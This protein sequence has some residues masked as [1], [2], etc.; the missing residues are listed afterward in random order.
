MHNFEALIRNA[1]QNLSEV[2][3]MPYRDEFF[4]AIDLLQDHESL[5]QLTKATFVVDMRLTRASYLAREGWLH[6]QR[7]TAP[8]MITLSRR[9]A[10]ST[11]LGLSLVDK[12]FSGHLI[13]LFEH[14][15]FLLG[16]MSLQSHSF[17]HGSD[18]EADT[19]L[20]NEPQVVE[21]RVKGLK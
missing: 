19:E 5:K 2:E 17:L 10:S 8:Q 14:V 18:S 3:L 15:F 20:L 12:E 6:I 13:D 4:A 9:T 1:T 21:V 16:P 11:P 7:L